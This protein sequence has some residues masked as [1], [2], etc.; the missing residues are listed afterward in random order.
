MNAQGRYVG[1][2]AMALGMSC[3]MHFGHASSFGGVLEP[4][5]HVGPPVAHS[6]LGDVGSETVSWLER[7]T[8]F[9]QGG[10]LKF[11]YF[12]DS[13]EGQDRLEVR[14]DGALAASFSGLQRTGRYALPVAAGPHTIRFGYRKDAAGDEGQD[15]AWIDDVQLVANGAPF[16]SYSFDAEDGG[17]TTD[18]T[19]GGY[20]GG[21]VATYGPAWMAVRRPA[22]MAFAGTQSSPSRAAITRSF[23]WP[24]GASAG[25]VMGYFVDSEPDH[26]PLRVLVDGA[27]V[28]SIS[29]AGRQGVVKI[30]L[31]AAGTHEITLEYV[32]D[33]SGDVGRD[34][35][36]VDF[37]APTSQG[38]PFSTAGFAGAPLG[39]LP[40]GWQPDPDASAGAWE[41]VS[42]APPLVA[43]LEAPEMPQVD[44]FAP[45]TEYLHGAVLNPN[46][47]AS[48]PAM[49]PRIKMTS[50]SERM[51]WQFELPEELG[52][53]FL[54]GGSLDLFVDGDA[55]RS[56]LGLGC[57][58][59]GSSPGD[60]ARRLH[61]EPIPADG[62]VFV[63][64][65][66]QVGDCWVGVGSGW[67]DATASEQWDVE[68]AAFHETESGSVLFEVG[69]NILRPADVPTADPI[70]F[71]FTLAGTLPGV[72]VE[73][74]VRIP[75]KLDR[76]LQSTNAAAWEI[77]YA[78]RPASSGGGS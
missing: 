32:K 74:L 38:Y 1:L 69:V 27:L 55:M 58:L 16:E 25:L 45:S 31:A 42:P 12:V 20:A 61:F 52:Q 49:R 30:P 23:D 59:H 62:E 72:G 67:R 54:A 34:E 53:W 17:G 46:H 26:D 68:G 14:V 50:Y 2:V 66:Q 48:L 73:E 36:R 29:G 4:S 76:D 56:S 75:W 37:L 44:G 57:G 63:E 5:Q 77:V 40:Q 8:T 70:G 13:E 6:M 33:E 65:E 51:Y 78:L 41:V 21:W 71:Q 64:V 15:T 7:S 3:G 9:E 35:A 28:W 10:E 60:F 43:L 39:G 22:T 47:M 24:A 18:W 11:R 19:A